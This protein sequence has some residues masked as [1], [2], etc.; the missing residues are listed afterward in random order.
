MIFLFT[1]RLL[2]LLRIN[3]CRSRDADWKFTDMSAL[4]SLRTMQWGQWK[5]RLSLTATMQLRIPFCES[6]GRHVVMELLPFG[7]RCDYFP[8][9]PCSRHRAY[10]SEIRYDQVFGALMKP[11]W[12]HW[13]SCFEGRRCPA[14]RRIWKDV[15]GVPWDSLLDIGWEILA[16]VRVSRKQER[17]GCFSFNVRHFQQTDCLLVHYF[18]LLFIH[19]W[20]WFG[21]SVRWSWRRF[22]QAKAND[23]C[24]EL[25]WK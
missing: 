9:L 6:R 12:M 10:Q 23:A 25:C 1:P 18:L 17:R 21:H 20:K 7:P 8:V 4:G 15:M 3:V 11:S 19:V 2:Q 13:L 14:S 22:R 16:P 5:M 24:L